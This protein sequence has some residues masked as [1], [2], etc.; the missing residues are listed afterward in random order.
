MVETVDSRHC[1]RQDGIGGES[2]QKVQIECLKR[3]SAFSCPTA[4]FYVLTPAINTFVGFEVT[5]AADAIL[6]AWN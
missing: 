2:S 4:R 6:A 5:S 3:E 1:R